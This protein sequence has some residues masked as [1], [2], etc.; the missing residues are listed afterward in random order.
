MNLGFGNF[1]L[2]FWFVSYLDNHLIVFFSF[3]LRS[4]LN[5]QQQRLQQPNP[6]G[7]ILHYDL[8]YSHYY[9]H[10]P[11]SLECFEDSRFT[12]LLVILVHA[13]LPLVNLVGVKCSLTVL[14]A[15]NLSLRRKYSPTLLLFFQNLIA[16]RLQSIH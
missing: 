5:L 9:F 10:L 2:G 16:S 3:V 6:H 11:T 12:K 8:G 4:I 14:Q 15:S 1:M 13:W 7:A